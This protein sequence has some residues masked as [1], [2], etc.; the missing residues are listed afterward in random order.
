MGRVSKV[1]ETSCVL[2]STAKGNGKIRDRVS[3]IHSPT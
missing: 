2:E 3:K 1:L